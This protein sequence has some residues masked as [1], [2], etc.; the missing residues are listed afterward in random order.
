[1]EKNG[2][3]L[4]DD[5]AMKLKNECVLDDP[6]VICPY[7][8]FQDDD[9]ERPVKM[10]SL[11]TY[12]L[13]NANGNDEVIIIADTRHTQRRSERK[14]KLF[15]CCAKEVLLSSVVVLR[16]WKTCVS[17]HTSVPHET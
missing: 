17:G 14:K 13:Q 8:P 1:M 11:E 9:T 7:I 3:Q 10:C 5:F 6:N 16:H 15:S 12:L 4:T 2:L